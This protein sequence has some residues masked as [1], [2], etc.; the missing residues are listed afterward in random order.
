MSAAPDDME[1]SIDAR[2]RTGVNTATNIAMHIT[3]AAIVRSDGRLFERLPMEFA[4]LVRVRSS[5]Q[6][7]CHVLWPVYPDFLPKFQEL[8]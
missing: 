8:G 3:I 1:R 7:L 4:S 6:G 2:A 5:M